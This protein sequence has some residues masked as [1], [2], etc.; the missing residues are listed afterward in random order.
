MQYNLTFQQVQEMLNISKNTLNG[1]I[2]LKYIIP[3]E[4][5]FSREKIFADLG[6]PVNAEIIPST[7]AA[8][9]L[10]YNVLVFNAMIKRKKIKRYYFGQ[11]T[12][13]VCSWFLKSDIDSID[14]NK[15][16]NGRPPSI[17]YKLDNNG[18]IINRYDGKK[19]SPINNVGCKKPIKH[20]GH[21]YCHAK[22]Y[23][24]AKLIIEKANSIIAEKEKRKQ[25]IIEKKERQKEQDKLEK[26]RKREQSKLEKA[27]QRQQDLY[28][29]LD[30]R[31]RLIGVFNIEEVCQNT[32]CSKYTIF[33]AMR[34]ATSIN[35]MY[36]V[37]KIIPIKETIISQ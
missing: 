35:G 1:Y 22:D 8:S 37:N 10:G 18:F 19:L 13:G 25:E 23:E 32:K 20:K 9:L 6:L 26:A 28:E 36:Y 31:K 11:Q 24:L 29:L 12:R 14:K 30:I 16:T 21:Y 17:I 7:L 15:M 2:R 4:K 3:K 34:K 5:L 27:K 33:K